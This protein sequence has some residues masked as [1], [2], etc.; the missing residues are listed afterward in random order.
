MNRTLWDRVVVFNYEDGTFQWIIPIEFIIDVHIWVSSSLFLTCY[1]YIIK[2]KCYDGLNELVTINCTEKQLVYSTASCGQQNFMIR[3]T[4]EAFSTCCY[5][6][7]VVFYTRSYHHWWEDRLFQD[8]VE[9]LTTTPR[10]SQEVNGSISEIISGDTFRGTMG[11][12]HGA[13]RG[14]PA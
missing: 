8:V 10:H 1:K 2:V 7:Q 4:K 12:S 9:F 6:I 5:K 14:E 13:S 11:N 3:S